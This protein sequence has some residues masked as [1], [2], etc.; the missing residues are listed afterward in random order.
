M[1]W[2][3]S[4]FLSLQTHRTRNDEQAEHEC[5]LDGRHRAGGN[6]LLAVVQVSFSRSS[7][8]CCCGEI[9]IG[10]KS[11]QNTKG[12]AR[13]AL[14]VAVNIQRKSRASRTRRPERV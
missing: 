8:N 13:Q 9:M 12:R 6:S 1:N 14:A 2:T 11:G 3:F 4:S 10:L 5:L 7:K